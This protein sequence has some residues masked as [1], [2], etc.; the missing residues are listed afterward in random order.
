MFLKP[1]ALCRS[2]RAESGGM[3]GFSNAL[4]MRKV[5]HSE[6]LVKNA[7]KYTRWGPQGAMWHSHRLACGNPVSEQWDPPEHM[8]TH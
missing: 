8:A 5:S 6:V 4:R 2:P 7:K 1:M 3:F